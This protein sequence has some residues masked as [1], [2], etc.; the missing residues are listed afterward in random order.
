MWPTYFLP[1]IVMEQPWLVYAG[2]VDLTLMSGGRHIFITADGLNLLTTATGRYF[3][4]YR[5]KTAWDIRTLR[6]QARFDWYTIGSSSD[7]AT[8]VAISADLT[9]LVVLSDDRL[10]RIDLAT[11][12]DI[13]TATAS[14]QSFRLSSAELPSQHLE[15]RRDGFSFTLTG[16]ATVNIAHSADY[17]PSI[18]WTLPT[19]DPVFTAGDYASSVNWPSVTAGVSAFKWRGGGLFAYVIYSKNATPDES[20]F[21]AFTFGSSY[22]LSTA[23][24]LGIDKSVPYIGSAQ[25]IN[26]VE[27]SNDG[28]VAITASNETAVRLTLRH[29]DLG[30]SYDVTGMTEDTS[31]LVRIGGH[32]GLASTWNSVCI[33]GD[34]LA[35]YALNRS[36]DQIFS[37][38][39]NEAFDALTAVPDHKVLALTATDTVP[40]SFYL[41]P[42]GEHLYVIGSTNDRVTEFSLSTPGDLNTATSVSF[43]SLAATIGQIG[44]A[45]GVWVSA[46]GVRMCISNMTG[47]TITMWTMST[48]FLV[49]SASRITTLDTSAYDTEPAAVQLNQAGTNLYFIGRASNKL[50]RFVLGTAFDLT[51]ATFVA[52]A[53]FSAY[54]A[55]AAGFA[56]GEDGNSLTIISQALVVHSLTVS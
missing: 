6:W 45:A 8:D 25:P 11:A 53:D 1:M 30:S 34:G 22:D 23:S 27:W 47:P 14:G 28:M 55:G 18:A 3:Q 31:R 35:L 48:P 17:V 4:H 42:D 50:F 32:I 37:F 12:G 9:K 41:T 39:I 13:T 33:S 56:F 5:F 51:T 15:A 24:Y 46:D 40:E 2:S 54:A 44:Y 10:W 43:R 29:W 36:S 20:E 21:R 16:S 7:A 19:G 49:S 38:E 26:D 52:E